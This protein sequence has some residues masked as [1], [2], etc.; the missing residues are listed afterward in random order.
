MVG[1]QSALALLLLCGSSGVRATQAVV[2]PV[3]LKGGN[4]FTTVRIGSVDLKAVIDTG[5][6]H[7]IGIAPEAV[8]KL[9]VRFTG[10]LTERTDGGGN[11]FRGREFRIPALQLGGVTYRNILGFERRQAASGDFGGP[12]LF[13]ALIGRGFLERYT[14]VVDYPH[15]RFELYPASRAREVCG[16]VTA[17]ILPNADGFM[18]STIQT[19]DG[20]MNLGWDTGA[21]YSFVQKSLA[22]ARRLGLKDDLYSTRRFAMGQLDAGAMDLVA[23]DLTG[24]PDV[25]GLIGFNFFEKHRVCFDYARRTVSVQQ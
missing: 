14:V 21:T 3:E 16:P 9:H 11:K 7:D 6:W 23:I 5:G 4:N 1:V 17:T 8:A 25:D 24:V 22:N 20:P 10:T 15:Q 2:I 19:D 13:E 12:P 18:F